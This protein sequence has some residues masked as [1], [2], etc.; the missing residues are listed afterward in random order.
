MTLHW[1]ISRCNGVSTPA[2]TNYSV[3]ELTH[4]LVHTGSQAIFT[5]A[6]LLETALKAARKADIPL[7][8][9]FV[10]ELP[11][12]VSGSAHTPSG[13]KTLDQ[14]IQDGTRLPEVEPQK[15]SKGQGKRQVA[16]IVFS[17]GTTGLPVRTAYARQLSVR[18]TNRALRKV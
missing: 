14:L 18:L 8:R 9:I 7:H 17:S 12:Q 2:N 11:K 10:C 3:D 13:F 6:P 15:W 1:A 4:Q 5:C 16:F